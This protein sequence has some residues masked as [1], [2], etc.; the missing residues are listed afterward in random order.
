MCTTTHTTEILSIYSELYSKSLFKGWLPKMTF[1]TET[2]QLWIPQSGY[3]SI[4]Y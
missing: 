3:G 1:H 2:V 4:M